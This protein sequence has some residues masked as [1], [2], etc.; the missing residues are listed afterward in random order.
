LGSRESFGPFFLA[1]PND[2][3]GDFWILMSY[4][5][6]FVCHFFHLQVN[7]PFDKNQ[8]SASFA[9][10]LIH[11]AK[12]NCVQFVNVS[13]I[14]EAGD[15]AYVLK[16]WW[17]HFR[18]LWRSISWNMEGHRSGHQGHAGTGPQL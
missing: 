7:S 18:I 11:V 17:V 15:E 16:F 5:V 10:T 12:S 13:K 1:L 9:F 2:E 4:L 14:P 8:K 6:Q 3:Y